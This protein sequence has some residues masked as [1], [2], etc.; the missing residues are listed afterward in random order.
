[1]DEELLMLPTTK[2]YRVLNGRIAGFIDDLEAIA[3]TVDKILSTSR[4]QY[5]IYSD[6]YGSDFLDLIGEDKDLVYS[7]IERMTV[8]ALSIDERITDVT[9]TDIIEVGRSEIKVLLTVT[10]VYGDLQVAQ[11][12]TF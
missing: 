6:D 2:T 4:F 1:M 8:E 9:V 3:Q 10:T 7:E 12:V 5:L 11:E